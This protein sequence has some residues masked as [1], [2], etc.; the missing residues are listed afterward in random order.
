MIDALGAVTKGLLKGLENLEIRGRV[1][2]IQTTALLKLERILRRV[3]ET[4]CHLNFSEK[5]SANADMKNFLGVNH[6]NNNNNNRQD[7]VSLF[8]DIS[9]FVDDLK[10]K[11]SF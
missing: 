3:L 8:Y 10:P 9:T 11:P 1:E 5:P 2:T 7:L 6:N 4:C